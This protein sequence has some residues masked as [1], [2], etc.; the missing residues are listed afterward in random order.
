MQKSTSLNFDDDSGPVGC[1]AMS[2]G[3]QFVTFEGIAVL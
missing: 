3:E 1:D 2:L